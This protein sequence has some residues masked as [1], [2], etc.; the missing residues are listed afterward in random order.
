MSTLLEHSTY[1]GEQACAAQEWKRVE[2][3]AVVRCG[4]HMARGSSMQCGASTC[5][6]RLGSPCGASACARRLG[7]LCGCPP[8]P[9]HTCGWENVLDENENGLLGRKLYTL[10]NDVHELPYCEVRGHQVPA[11]T[12]GHHGFTQP[13][14]WHGADT[15]RAS[16]RPGDAA[17]AEHLHSLLLV[18]VRDV[19][20][21]GLLHNHLQG[22]IGAST[23]QLLQLPLS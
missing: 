7:C 13:T 8:P 12:G 23:G 21:L 9:P 16:A 18:N 19:A 11:H 17:A 15:A 5:A 10:S 14:P 22:G 1:S 3:V 6:R 20:L 2:R 4:V